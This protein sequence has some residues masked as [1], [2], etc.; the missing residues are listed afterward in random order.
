[1]IRFWKIF[2]VATFTSLL[3]SVCISFSTALSLSVWIP[4]SDNAGGGTSSPGKSVMHY[5]S[6]ASISTLPETS[7]PSV[8]LESWAGLENNSSYSCRACVYRVR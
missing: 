8:G 6:M 4:F 1:M 7:F 5:S 3:C 2:C